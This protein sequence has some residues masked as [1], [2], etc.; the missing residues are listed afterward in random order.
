MTGAIRLAVRGHLIR[1]ANGVDDG[2]GIRAGV[3]GLAVGRRL[4]PGRNSVD[5]GAPIGVSLLFATVL[6]DNCKLAAWAGG[7]AR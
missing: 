6:V 5:K 7:G 4:V 3:I 2:R 1:G